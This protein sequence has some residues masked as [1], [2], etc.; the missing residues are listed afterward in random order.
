MAKQ[1]SK[2][3]VLV[4]EDE[5]EVGNFVS[6]V[7]EFEGYQV[8][9]AEDGDEGLRLLRGGNIG[10]VALDLS[11]T[12]HDGWSVMAEMKKEP[13]LS[14]ILIVVITTSPGVSQQGRAV[15][16]GPADYMVEPLSAASLRETVNRI[17]H[18]K[19]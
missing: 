12:G 5:T 9:Q 10:L 6:R 8:L 3:M 15:S 11:V 1:D 2:K 14:A 4:I 16:I 18:G 13:E 7:L 17:L 19:R